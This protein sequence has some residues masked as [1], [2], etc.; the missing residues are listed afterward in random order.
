[1]K[2]R[3]ELLA[4]DLPRPKKSE[5]LGLGYYTT[6]TKNGY[7]PIFD[8]AIREKFPHWF[9]NTRIASNKEK[10]LALPVGTVRPSEG[11]NFEYSKSTYDPI[12]YQTCQI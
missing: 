7:D 6:A 2:K 5:N 3:T 4:E 9:N 8:K 11:H 1:M 10:L 12:F